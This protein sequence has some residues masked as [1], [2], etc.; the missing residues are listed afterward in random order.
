MDSVVLVANALWGQ[1]FLNGLRL[2]GGTVLICSTD[3][4][5][6]VAAES[7]VSGKHIC[8]QDAANDVT[9]MRHVV[10]V[11]QRTRDE[12]VSLARLLIWE[13]LSSL[14]QSL[15]FG[16]SISVLNIFGSFFLSLFT[17]VLDE[18]GKGLKSCSIRDLLESS[19][20]LLVGKFADWFNEAVEHCV[21]D[22]ESTIG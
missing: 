22:T 18:G 1:A 3:V 6:V 21:Q 14:V 17:L 4:H 13:D 7:A 11:R 20:H 5:G 8:G 19:L 10:D 15:Q 2:G 9:K 16:N 12:D